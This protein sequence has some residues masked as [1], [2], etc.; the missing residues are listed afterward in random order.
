MRGSEDGFSYETFSN[1]CFN[2]GETLTIVMDTEGN[3]FGGYTDINFDGSDAWKSDG[4]KNS[5]LFAF[6]E[7]RI[8]KCKC[9]N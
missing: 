1:K 9:I 7:G 2:K 6:I 8:V 5:F 3:I 4:N